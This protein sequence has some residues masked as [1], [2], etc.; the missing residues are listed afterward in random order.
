M[1]TIKNGHIRRMRHGARCGLVSLSLLMLAGAAQAV[2]RLTLES[3]SNRPDKLSGGDVLIR[4]SLP[5]P[6][7]AQGLRV[8]LNDTDVSA[9]FRPS[10]NGR[11]LVGL[12]QGLRDGRNRLVARAKGAIPARL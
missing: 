4:I 11:S 6:T 9:A 12:V 1:K 8:M 5:N 7:A 2:P 3:L 10:Q